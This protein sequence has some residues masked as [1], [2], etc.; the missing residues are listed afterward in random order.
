MKK[1]L[2]LLVFCIAIGLFT[3]AQSAYL[4]A[5]SYTDA[6]PADGIQIFRFNPENGALKNCGHVSKIINPSY[7]TVAASGRYL[8]ACTEAKLPT[9]GK[10][11]A[12]A[13]EDAQGRLDRL[14]A[15]PSGGVN[16]VHV[17]VHPRGRWV[18][19]ANYA[20]GNITVFPVNADGSL[21]PAVQN[22]AFQDS[23]IFKLRQEKSHPHACVFSPDGKFL[24][25]PDL[26]ADKIRA[27]E[28]R[29]DEVH[30]IFVR[31][32]LT[33]KIVGASGP[34]HFTFHPNEKWAYCVEE[35]SGTVAAYAYHD[36]LMDSL[37]RIFAYSKKHEVYSGADIHISPDGRF[38]YASNRL[39]TENTLAIF[40]ID[41]AS[42]RLALLGH[43]STLGDHPRNFLIDPSGRFLI[44]ANQVS[45]NIVVFARDL[46]TGLLTRI[47]RDVRMKGVS[48]LWMLED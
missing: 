37:Q 36:G 41:Q 4:Y 16:P 21:Q 25:V 1:R 23:S 13:I 39:D 9:E 35:L 7:V 19:N 12:F 20:A 27:F 32:D 34:R 33:I 22:I 17:C 47:G 18:V 10:V 8:Y 30:P 31:E 40:S 24:F 48:S 11:T 14:N 44:V 46:E 42:G 6:K 26:G 38:L 45:G 29:E 28:F 2:L 3:Q 43:Q 5:G 15:Q